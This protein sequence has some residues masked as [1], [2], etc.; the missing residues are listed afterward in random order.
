MNSTSNPKVLITGAAGFIG[1]H[2]SHLLSQ[3]KMNV[4]G[5]DS[6]NSYYSTKLKSDRIAQLSNF[7]N[8]RFIQMD[9]CDKEAL[10]KL[11]EQERFDY[12]VNLAAQAGVR[13][14]IEQPYKYIDSNLIG[15]INI[16]EAC[17]Q[18]PVKHLVYASSSSV[19]GNSNNIPFSTK[20]ACNEPVS[21]Y[22]ATKK[23]NEM[24][25]HSYAELYQTPVTGLRFFTVYGPYGRPDM[26]YF[27][28]TKKIING[29][30]IQ[31]YNE[32]NL[33]RD[34]TYIDDI[35]E[36]IQKLLHLPFDTEME[37]TKPYRLFN[38]GN[39]K[40]VKL[41]TFINTLEKHIGTNAIKTFLPMQKGD[42]YKTFADITP[43][44][45]RI[46]FKPKTSI[47]EGLN[48]FVSWYKSYYHHN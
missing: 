25:A 5:I 47:D 1:F 40:P 34:F 12:V 9:I 32:G 14:S 33:E 21:L 16:L 22:A 31:V 20:E 48:Q 7:E 23:A 11:F 24:M 19:Y 39:N 4:V 38:I 45:K 46:N 18:F 29:D 10:D 3:S 44:E 30:S 37:K 17:R 6:L 43:L 15:F 42:V 2:L 13:Y 41:M 36:A 28:F 35:V 26:A 8:F 27:S